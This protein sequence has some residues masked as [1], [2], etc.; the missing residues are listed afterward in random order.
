[1][2]RA[3]GQCPPEPADAPFVPSDW[4]I[5][6][7][8]LATVTV[9]PAGLVM[10]PPNLAVVG[11]AQLAHATRTHQ[12]HAVNMLGKT[13]TI[14]FHAQEFIFDFGDGSH[15]VVSHDPGAPYPDMTNQHTY[16]EPIESTHL[17]LTTWWQATVT[18][19]W[20]GHTITLHEKLK[21]VE[22]TP[23]FEVKHLHIAL[24]D[25]AEELQGH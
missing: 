18:N 3:R 2:G 12:E 21:T 10:Q 24:T 6:R 8:A 16:E 11:I 7:R 9:E 13:V 22:T 14:T 1:M 5:T 25:T 15:P 19:P 4:Q 23:P 17:T 20:T